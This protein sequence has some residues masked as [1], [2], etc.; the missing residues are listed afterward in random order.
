MDRLALNQEQGRIHNKR[1]K[2]RNRQV[3]WGFVWAFAVA[4]LQGAWY[5]PS[6]ALHYEAPF[7]TMETSTGDYLLGALVLTTLNAVAVLLALFLWV[8]VLGK[9]RDYVRTLRRGR[10]S[11]WYVP[12]GLLGGPVAIYGTFLA[13]GFVGGVFGAVAAV[14]FPIVGA[15]TARIWFHEKITGQAA[16]G[17][18]VL[19]IGA[20]VVFVPG[21]VAEL[22]GPSDGVWLGYVGGAM[23]ILGWGFEGAVAARALDVSDADVGFPL[24]S[25]AEVFCWIVLVLPIT[26]VFVGQRLW[27]TLGSALANPSVCW[28]LALSGPIFGF[29]YVCWYKSFPLIGVGRGQAIAIL[30][31]PIGVLWL[32]LF[33][34]TLPDLNFVVG[35]MLAVGGSFLLFLEKRDMLE[36]IRA[37]PKGAHQDTS[38]S[39]G[40]RASFP[41]SKESRRPQE[42]ARILSSA[43]GME[44][45]P[46]MA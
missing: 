17:I 24:R 33:T 38:L 9:G 21:I 20:V 4:V 22:S 45:I 8:L 30:F 34:L 12:A 16:L 40:G 23:A 29:C 36:V 35:A 42:V 15:L 3:R 41:E 6:T 18:G 13:I 27:D 11:L 26:G 44:R 10:I 46:H 5:V 25:T 43:A 2:H 37:A 1:Q 7:N 19:V 39:A 14:L 28:L 32:S 31:G